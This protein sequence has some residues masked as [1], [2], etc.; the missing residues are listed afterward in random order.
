MQ[1]EKTGIAEIV[2]LTRILTD[3]FRG[4]PYVQYIRQFFICSTDKREKT[5]GFF[6]GGCCQLLW[7]DLLSNADAKS[8]FNA[9]YFGT[10]LALR[11]DADGIVLR[12]WRRGNAKQSDDGTISIGDFADGHGQ[13]AARAV[14]FKAGPA[15]SVSAA[16]DRYDSRNAFQQYQHVFTSH[17]GSERI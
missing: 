16:D 15:R 6:S 7:D 2:P 12:F 9:Q 3:Y 1:G 11:F 4:V 13:Y 17:Y 14:L 5:A 8:F 10:R